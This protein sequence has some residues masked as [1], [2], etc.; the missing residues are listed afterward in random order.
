MTIQH[1]PVNFNSTA[2]GV[3]LRQAEAAL[4]ARRQPA[5]ASAV[6]VTRMQLGRCVLYC[7]APSAWRRRCEGKTP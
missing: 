5:G 4:S 3:Y 7:V 6:A 1:H 2:S